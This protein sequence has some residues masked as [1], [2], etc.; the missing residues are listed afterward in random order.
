MMVRVVQSSERMISPWSVPSGLCSRQVS[1]QGLRRAPR[2][3]EGGI[4]QHQGGLD[5]TPSLGHHP[6]L[7]TKKPKGLLDPSLGDR[8]VSRTPRLIRAPR[9]GRGRR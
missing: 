1:L 4:Y 5:S 6:S 3:T 2:R 9:C 8:S 7:A